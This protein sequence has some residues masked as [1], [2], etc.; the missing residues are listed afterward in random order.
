MQA[1][2]AEIKDR[3]YED[4]FIGI[5][6]PIGT[7]KDLT[8]QNLAKLVNENFGYESHVLKLSKYISKTYPDVFSPAKKNECKFCERRNKIIYGTRLR[9]ATQDPAILAKMAIAEIRSLAEVNPNFG[10]RDDGKRRVFIF[11][12]LKRREEVNYL[13]SLYGKSFFL[14]GLH[15]P[16]EKRLKRIS[17][18]INKPDSFSQE[19]M[20]LDQS[21]REYFNSMSSCST[22]Q[23]VPLHSPLGSDQ[24][25]DYGQQL[26]DIYPDSDLFISDYDNE[27]ELLRFLDLIFGSPKEFP[28][29]S[30]HAMYLAFSA[31]TRSAD[32]SR[33]VGAAIL[34]KNGDLISVGSNDVPKSG[35]GIYDYTD[36]L[37]D[38]AFGFEANSKRI[39]EIAENIAQTIISKE[40]TTEVDKKKLVEVILEKTDIGS[41]TEFH[42]AVHAEM[43]AI[44]SATRSG[45]SPKDGTIFVTTFP[46][47]NC[48]KHIVS[49]GLREV[50]FVEPYPKSLAERLHQDAIAI[51]ED[52]TEVKDRVSVR[53]FLGVGPRRFLDLFSMKLSAGQSVRRK[54]GFAAKDFI[55][56]KCPMRFA[57]FMSPIEIER[58]AEKIYL[59]EY[60][61][62]LE[63]LKKTTAGNNSELENE[64]IRILSSI[65]G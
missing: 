53:P 24:K 27:E 39:S 29:T 48:A 58:S 55:R 19:L 43:Q 52:G 2:Q 1:S 38:G 20:E 36:H 9:K 60:R 33:Q 61:S 56:A 63:K 15:S 46:C 49:A 50:I 57:Q 32:L 7:D 44:L 18:E 23:T 31:S 16:T 22:C 28:S 42:R 62:K 3:S 51:I 59:M 13:A 8:T 21:E 47:H 54:D 11:D 25:T 6:A 64:G 26:R 30:E 41:L 10:K 37:N 14:L 65:A 12:Q 45:V 5:L 35:G 40:I 4:L 17:R 34:N